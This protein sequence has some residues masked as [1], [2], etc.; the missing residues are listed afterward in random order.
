MVTVSLIEWC[1]RKLW[2]SSAIIYKKIALHNTIILMITHPSLL[3]QHRYHSKSFTSSGSAVKVDVILLDTIDLCDMNQAASEE[4]P[5]YFD[6]LPLRTRGD[7]ADNGAQWSWLE[8]Q[9]AASTAD[10]LIVGGHFPVY[11]VCDHGPNPTLI[12]HLRPL[13][14]Q[15]GAHYLSGHDHCMIHM[16]EPGEAVNY[17]LSGIGDTCCYESSNK[18]SLIY[19]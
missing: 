5:G 18:V 1:N 13:L 11:S 19:R 3:N 8:Q 2:S 16:Q 12:E 4:E 7:A 9:M 6:P 15:Y 14:I 17:V 10:Y